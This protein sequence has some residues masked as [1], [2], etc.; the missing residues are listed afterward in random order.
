V[1]QNIDLTLNALLLA[2]QCQLT[3]LRGQ[4]GLSASSIIESFGSRVEQGHSFAL[5]AL[6]IGKWVSAHSMRVD[7]LAGF[8]GFELQCMGGCAPKLTGASFSTA[9]CAAF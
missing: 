7:R 4:W 2:G 8:V 1:R 3:S 9:K 6:N 5:H